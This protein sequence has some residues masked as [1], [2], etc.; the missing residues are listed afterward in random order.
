MVSDVIENL[1]ADKTE[2]KL[3]VD[4][5][6]THEEAVF[7]ISLAGNFVMSSLDCVKKSDKRNPREDKKFDLIGDI[8]LSCCST[9]DSLCA[10]AKDNC[11]KQSNKMQKQIH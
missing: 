9:S 1:K 8:H 3:N 7:A 11:A 2:S 6:V 4:Y 5:D 10:L